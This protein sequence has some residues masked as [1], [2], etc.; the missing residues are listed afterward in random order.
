MVM[1]C[2]GAPGIAFGRLLSLRHLDGPGVRA[3]LSTA[4][5]TTLRGGFGASY[6]LCHGDLGAIEVLHLAGKVLDE[7]RWTWSALQR[8]AVVVRQGREGGWRCGLPRGSESPG[9]L[10]GL[11]GIGYGLLRLSAPEHVPNLLALEQPR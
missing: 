2:H 8:A 1:W 10:M 7:P 4:L 11:A 5:E 6:C 3:E 9:L